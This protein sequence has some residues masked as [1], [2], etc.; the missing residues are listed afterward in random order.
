MLYG[1]PEP[2]EYIVRNLPDLIELKCSYRGELLGTLPG[3]GGCQLF[4]C[5]LHGGSC[6]KHRDNRPGHRFCGDCPDRSV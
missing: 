4:Y 3:C 2:Q 6:T 5:S 1:E